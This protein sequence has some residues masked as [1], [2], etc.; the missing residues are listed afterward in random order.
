M[1]KI[2]IVTSLYKSAPY[3]KEFYD[4]HIACVTKL[5]VDYEFVFVNDGSPDNSS[6]IVN[7]II[8]NDKRVRLVNLSRNFGQYPAM[9]AGMSVAT[10]DY[11]CALDCDLEE[12]PENIIPMYE[13]L[14]QNASIDVV[15]TVIDKRS[16]GFVKGFL[17][18]LFF[19]FMDQL[20]EVN[21][22]RN[23][24]WQ[25]LMSK[26]YVES[27]LQYKEVETLPAGLMVLAG[28]NQVPFKITK[29]YKGSTSYTLKKR[30]RFAFN[31]LFAF[32]SK[33]LI[34]IG[35]SG[36]LI[37]TIAFLTIVIAL[38][39]KFFYTNYQSG[40]I[41]IIAS[42][43][44]IGGLILSSI[45]IVGIYISKI[46]NQIKNRPLYIIKSIN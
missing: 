1:N 20:S 44:F 41:S 26:K 18:E 2:S 17:G 33:P 27:L 34:F 37:T 42:I 43:W 38:L 24:G 19:I 28:F 32:S 45:G 14:K 11:V 3:I 4:R 7:R 31:S 30:L 13:K 25:R 40:W 29:T 23:Q 10:G 16:G 15:Y 6:D 35:I 5:A 39:K 9:F 36:L 12:D 8:E 22:P 21:I 46:F